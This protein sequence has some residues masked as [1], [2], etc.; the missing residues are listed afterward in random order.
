[1]GAEMGSRAG[2]RMW[3]LLRYGV[4]GAVMA[5]ALTTGC[6]H[7]GASLE[8]APDV[9]LWRAGAALH[10]PVWS[11]RMHSL[12]ALTDDHRLAEVTAVPSPAE[13]ATSKSSEP[14]CAAGE[15]VP[16]KWRMPE[17]PNRW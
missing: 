6:S 5:A 17:D 8:S 10:E 1:M 11:Y 12:V 4:V 14:R 7:P 15:D 3:A 9:E 16:W 2:Q 13:T